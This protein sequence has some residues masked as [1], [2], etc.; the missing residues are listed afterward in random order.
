MEITHSCE[1]V[2][3]RK[4]ENRKTVLMKL[5]SLAT[6]PAAALAPDANN[7]QQQQQ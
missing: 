5:L 6:A 4:Y 3:V 7:E 1:A 2:A